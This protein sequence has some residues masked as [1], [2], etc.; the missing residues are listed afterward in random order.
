MTPPTPLNTETPSPYSDS[1]PLPN[2]EKFP[3]Y[4]EKHEMF[5]FKTIQKARKTIN[6][7]EKINPKSNSSLEQDK[8]EAEKIEKQAIA[9]IVF[10]YTPKI[11]LIASTVFLIVKKSQENSI[12]SF[13]DVAQ[14]THIGLMMAIRKFDPG[15]NKS[16]SNTIKHFVE[17]RVYKTIVDNNPDIGPEGKPHDF[18]E[19]LS[20]TT[21]LD[22]ELSPED[23]IISKEKIKQQKDI[24][25]TLLTENLSISEIAEK[26]EL[27]EEKVRSI[28][29]QIS[30]ISPLLLA[31]VL[32]SKN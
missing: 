15:K 27:K 31:E 17:T 11:Q 18:F 9:Q 21:T 10:K 23:Q 22:S 26:F 2:P 13:E 6:Q 30:N 25:K 19:E 29:K 5:L 3:K 24:L 32:P 4:T 16:F 7:I 28:K 14:A 8:E 12:L 1:E 20:E